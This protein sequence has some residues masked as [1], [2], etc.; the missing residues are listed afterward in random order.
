M[1][2]IGV[3]ELRQNASRWLA[4]VKAGESFVVTER[5][6]AIAQLTPLR[7]ALPGTRLAQLIDDGLAQPAA[8]PLLAALD[9]AGGPT[10]GPPLSRR[11]E[12]LRVDER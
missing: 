6:R 8:A 12:E 2:E 3:R 7:A 5:G 9:A 10:A 4:R 11:L 1:V